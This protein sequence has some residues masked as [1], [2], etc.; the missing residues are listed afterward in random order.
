MKV[1]AQTATRLQKKKKIFQLEHAQCYDAGLVWSLFKQ[2]PTARETVVATQVVWVFLTA[3]PLS[4]D[5]ENG[6]KISDLASIT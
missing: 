1:D 3:D 5:L 6:N 2:G 4:M